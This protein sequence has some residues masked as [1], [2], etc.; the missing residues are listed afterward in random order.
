MEYKYFLFRPKPFEKESLSSYL[1]RIAD[2]NYIYV[3]EI[4]KLLLQSNTHYPQ[5]SRSHLLDICPNSTINLLKLAEALNF[6][7]N[8]IEQLSFVPVYKN[9]YIHENKISH[10]RLLSGLI[11]KHRKYCPECMREKRFYKLIWQVKEIN[12]CKIHRIK[13]KHY[14]WQCNRKIP[15]VPSEGKIGY[16]PYCLADLSLSIVTEE[17]I[18]LDDRIYEDWEY[19]LELHS[20]NFYITSHNLKITQLLSLKLL[21]ISEYFSNRKISGRLLQKARNNKLSKTIIHLDNIL[22]IIRIA[23]ITIEDFF[24]LQI[25]SE[26]IDKILNPND[27]KILSSNHKMIDNFSCASPWCTNYKIPGSLKRTAS[28]TKI[29]QDGPKYSFYMYCPNCS[30]TYCLTHKDNKL[31]ERGYFISIGWHKVRPLILDGKSI[32]ETSVMLDI[33]EYIVTRSIIFMASNNLIS[34]DNL[35]LMIPKL[36]EKK[37][38]DFFK[39]NIISGVKSNDIR[40]K[41]SLSYNEFLYYWLYAE[42]HLEHIKH[43]CPKKN[44]KK[45]I[46]NYKEKIDEAV[47]HLIMVNVPIT[48][49]KVC[50]QAR[51]SHETLRDHGLLKIIKD[52]KAIQKESINIKRKKQLI[53]NAKNIINEK[54]RKGED[55]IIREIYNSL[56]VSHSSISQTF[57]EISKQIH[58]LLND[59]KSGVKIK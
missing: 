30:I 6:D 8:I 39:I 32:A 1:Q 43:T 18:N 33:S 49:R 17:K 48:V 42:I 14:C 46:V 55:I 12:C 9:F 38:I 34:H 40:K 2:A 5:S 4:W 28:L 20:H 37:I 25:P 23:N 7:K 3:N 41:L 54:I 51:V 31:V 56:G 58:L 47:N 45:S 57:P 35:P 52:K 15:L 24:N 11:E 27:N 59:A 10:S 53:L 13:L 22:K 19:L 50:N 26:F 21:Y 16:C 29:Y 36:H 44:N